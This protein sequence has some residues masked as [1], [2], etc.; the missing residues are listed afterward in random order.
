MELPSSVASAI[1]PSALCTLCSPGNIQNR[2]AKFFA[3]RDKRKK[4]R[5]NPA[6]RHRCRD[7]RHSRKIRRKQRVSRFAQTRAA[8]R[9]VGA[10][11]DCAA[12]LLDELR[13]NFL[14]RCKVGIKIE[15]L[16]LDIQNEG[17]LRMEERSVPSLSSPS[18]TKYSPRESQ[19][20]FVPRIGISAPT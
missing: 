14:D 3:R 18:A 8:L 16:F 19:C 15:M 13:K 17:V 2:F 10:V 11:K 5:R 1:T 9:I 20:A 6:A 12:G 7:N 4:P